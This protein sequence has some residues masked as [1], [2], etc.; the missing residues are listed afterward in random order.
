MIGIASACGSATIINAIASGRGAAFAVD[1][2]VKSKVELKEDSPEIKGRV[3][4]TDED[5]ELIETCV[6]KVLEEQGVRGDFGARVETTTELPIAAG[7]SSSSAAANATVLA[8]YSALEEDPEPLDA[9]DMGI[10]AAFEAGTTVTGALDDAS[11]SYL[12]EGVITDNENREILKSFALDPNLKVIIYIPPQKSY[13]TE[14]DVDRTKLLKEVV[15][16][17]LE[18]ALKGKIFGAQTVNGL[19]YSS[20]LGYDPAP[21][22]DAL[23]AGAESSGLTGTGPAIVAISK[24]KNV[25]SII[26]SWSARRGDILETRPSRKGAKVEDEW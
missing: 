23:E 12:G 15:D 14:I 3:G 16:F 25:E 21:A 8:T 20:V 18:E 2:R 10:E 24:E 5:S 26:N 4:G 13:T 22:L 1:M 7:L 11:A 19:L 17:A 6:D 9:V